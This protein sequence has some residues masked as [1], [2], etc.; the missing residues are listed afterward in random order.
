MSTRLT[1]R[2]IN[3]LS[4]AT[5]ANTDTGGP[6]DGVDPTGDG[7]RI[8][9]G[10]VRFG[11][12]ASDVATQVRLDVAPTKNRCRSQN[13]AHGS[14]LGIHALGP[15]KCFESRCKPMRFLW[16]SAGNE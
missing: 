2:S 7:Q 5:T 15:T 3:H 8:I 14:R 6:D 11:I 13:D 4:L 16:A 10:G 9:G 1:T 12:V